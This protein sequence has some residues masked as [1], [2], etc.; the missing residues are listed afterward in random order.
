M[1]KDEEGYDIPV[2]LFQKYVTNRK[3][4]GTNLLGFRPFISSGDNLLAYI[5]QAYQ[6]MTLVYDSDIS[7]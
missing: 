2:D 5:S 1:K 6:S 4:E 7:Y 3:I